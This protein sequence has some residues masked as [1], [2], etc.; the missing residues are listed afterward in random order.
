MSNPEKKD[1]FT[2]LNRPA[3]AARVASD[4][5]E[6]WYVNLG[7]GMPTMVADHVPADREVI[8]HSEN[9]LLGMGPAPARGQED[10]WVINAGKQNVTLLKGAALVHH[11]DSFT[12]I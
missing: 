10:P 5:P 7:I 3:M 9:G 2:P 8:F 1:A 6:G 11:A 12:M 4:I